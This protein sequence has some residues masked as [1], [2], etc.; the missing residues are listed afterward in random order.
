[1]SQ[2]GMPELTR[3]QEPTAWTPPS[4]WTISPVVIV[5]QSDMRATQAR[6]TTSLSWTSQPSGARSPQVSSKAAKPGMDL[7]AMV[8]T[9]P[10]ATRF[11]R[12]PWGPSSLA[13]YRVRDSRAALA[14]P[15]QSYSGQATVASKSRPTTEA[16]PSAPAVSNSGRNAS[17]RAFSEY[18]DTWRAW[19]TSPQS[20]WN[21]P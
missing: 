8:R 13:R 17:T 12:T 15:I 9:G 1:M 5:N 3:R 7:A 2:H 11:T 6:A 18:V 4:T 14:T 19:D 21:M 16:P 20:A 10:A